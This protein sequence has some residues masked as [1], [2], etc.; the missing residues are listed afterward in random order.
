MHYWCR[1]CQVKNSITNHTNISDVR[2]HC[3][4]KQHIKNMQVG[5]KSYAWERSRVCVPQFNAPCT[6][7]N[8]GDIVLAPGPCA[9]VSCYAYAHCC[10]GFPLLL[11][12]LLLCWQV[13]RI[14]AFQMANNFCEFIQH[15][16]GV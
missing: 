15:M 7:G 4:T 14:G 8:W 3:G 16:V 12:L 5:K 9:S 11:L 2:Q 10:D 6:H 1:V 13:A